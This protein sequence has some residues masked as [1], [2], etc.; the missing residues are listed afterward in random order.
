MFKANHLI[1]YRGYYYFFIRIPSDLKH[2][3]PC[4]FIKKSLKTRNEAEAREQVIPLEHKVLRC[5]RLLRSGLL[6]DDQ[7]TDLILELGPSKTKEKKPVAF[8][9][10]D[11]ISRYVDHHEKAWAPKTKLEN[12]GSF[13]LIQ[14]ILGDMELKVINKQVVLDFRK[15]LISLPANMYKLYPGRTIKQILSMQSITPMSTT[16]ANKHLT[17][18]SSLLKYAV[19]EGRMLV[20]YAEGMQVQD[21]R[22]SDEVRKSYS[23]E[24]LKRIIAHIPM[25][26][27]QPERYWVPILGM[28]SG[29]R[30]D[31]ICQLYVDD[32]RQVDGVW[33]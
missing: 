5:F 12:K 6:A 14:E 17:R 21:K 33:L 30:L 32:I 27:D 2:L 15:T 9:L 1:T 20:N 3:F 28:F 19:Q 16:S 18:L 24:D 7:V 10:S 25:L 13:K 22:R 4:T 29:M 11:M 31:E 23:S 26:G 8:K